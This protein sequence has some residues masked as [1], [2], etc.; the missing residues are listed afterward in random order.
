MSTPRSADEAAVVE[1]EEEEEELSD[2]LL[3]AEPRNLAADNFPLLL[4][5]TSFVNPVLDL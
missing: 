2:L 4:P 1:E 3:K 5:A